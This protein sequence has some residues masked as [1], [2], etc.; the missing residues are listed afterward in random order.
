M[1]ILFIDKN[2]SLVRRVSK[3]FWGDKRVHTRSGDIFKHKGVIV[4]ASNPQ[5]TFGGGLDAQI[6][7]HYPFECGVASTKK[8]RNQRVG[9]VIF[10]V[11]VGDD[12]IATPRLVKKALRFA[13]ANVKEGETLLLTGLGT[14]IGGLS[15]DAFVG[16]L[17]EVMG[18][19]QPEKLEEWLKERVKVLEEIK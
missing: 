15:E 17:L 1:N 4:S 12:Y 13:I 8:G 6:K 11:T 16:L 14:G 5:F 3:A 9:N 7:R 10:T 2:K 18:K 19:P